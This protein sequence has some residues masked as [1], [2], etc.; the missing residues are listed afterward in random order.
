M[1]IIIMFKY[2]MY[3]EREVFGIWT[4]KVILFNT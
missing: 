3:L 4:N 2:K 1:Y